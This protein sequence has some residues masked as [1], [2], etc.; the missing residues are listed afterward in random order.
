VS[1]CA[2]FFW[3]LVSSMLAMHQPA[4]AAPADLPKCD[5]PSLTRPVNQTRF[6][7]QDSYPPLSV[8]FGEEGNDLVSFTVNP[9]GTVGDV[10]LAEGSGSLRLDDAAVNAVKQL[11]YAPAKSG[12]SPVACRDSLRINWRLFDETPEQKQSREFL[13]LLE[14]PKSA[15]PKAALEADKE[16]VTE[17]AIRLN[18]QGVIEKANV[19]KGSGIQELD[20]AALIYVKTLKVKPAQIGAKPAGVILPVVVIWSKTPLKKSAP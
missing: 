14:P 9:N 1:K 5:L 6:S 11:I 12:G 7:L 4:A 15:W 10:A 19:V 20:D 3:V 18:A 8:F 13:A 2:S 17:V 16:G